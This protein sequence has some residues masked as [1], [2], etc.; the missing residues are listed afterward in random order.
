MSFEFE[1]V[2]LEEGDYATLYSFQK[3]GEEETELEK[4]WAKEEVRDA[5]DYENMQIRLYED[6]LMAQ[7]FS[8]VKCFQGPDRWFRAEGAAGDPDDINAEALC[9]DIPAKD[10]KKLRK[11]Y[12]RLRLF[13]FRKRKI[14]FAGNGAVKT[15]KRIQDDP[16][17]LAAWQDIR[18]VMECVHNR[19]EWTDALNFQR[20][21]FEDG[22]VEEDFILEG[23]HHF[24]L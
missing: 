3:E 14:L 4:F 10:R 8:H 11:P 20:I 13:C 18:Y 7:N 22:Y 9:T 24:E 19:I 16:E 17:L 1:L 6:V 23:N 21:E 2:L 12:P 15:T 5:P